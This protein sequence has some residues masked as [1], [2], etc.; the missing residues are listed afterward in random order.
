[1]AGWRAPRRSLGLP[2]IGLGLVPE[3]G[4]TQRLPR[5]VGAAAALKLMLEPAPM[6][7]AQA[8]TIGLVDQVVEGDLR[9]QACAFAE[10]MAAALQWGCA[11]KTSDRRDGLRDG[12]GFQA[13]IVAARARYAGSP[14]PAPLRLIECVEAAQLLPLEQGL[15]FEAAAYEALVHTPQAQGLRHAFYAERRAVLPPAPL[16]DCRRGQAGQPCGLGGG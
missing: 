2:E 13:A 5:L 7:A 9:A 6:S 4:A 12:R 1:M 14:L 11:L 10:R 15:A 3:A 16:A 8:L